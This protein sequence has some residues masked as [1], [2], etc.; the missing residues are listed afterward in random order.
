MACSEVGF[1]VTSGFSSPFIALMLF[2]VLR[3]THEAMQPFVQLK[4]FV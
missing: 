1:A 2:S 3:E 4:P